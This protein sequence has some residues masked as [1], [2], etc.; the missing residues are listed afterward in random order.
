MI[1]VNS[2]VIINK[3]KI[4]ALERKQ[5]KALENTAEYLH[6]EIVPYIPYN[7]PD[8]KEKAYLLSRGESTGGTLSGEATFVDTSESGLGKVS[9]ISSTPYARRLYYHPEYKF[10]KG[11]HPLAKGKWLEDFEAGGSR[12]KEIPAVF[13]RFFN[14]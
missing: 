14:L 3:P 9:I 1:K 7:D 13:N 11:E 5:I 12:A 6:T 8:E 2:R 10:D 4:K